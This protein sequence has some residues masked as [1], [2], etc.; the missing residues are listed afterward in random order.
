M[1]NEL[2][3]G[4]PKNSI[5]KKIIHDEQDE[6]GKSLKQSFKIFSTRHSPNHP[7]T[8][9]TEFNDARLLKETQ[10]EFKSSNQSLGLQTID[11]AIWLFKRNILS[12]RDESPYLWSE[13]QSRISLSGIGYTIHL[14]EVMQNQ[15]FLLNQ[16]ITH[17]Q[18]KKA[19]QFIKE[20]ESKLWKSDK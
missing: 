5:F 18:M 12:C 11:P 9:M 19:E 7:M 4:F 1:I 16:H 2:N 13:I 15:S 17:D 6:F 8:L 14:N 3:N 10:L 20:V